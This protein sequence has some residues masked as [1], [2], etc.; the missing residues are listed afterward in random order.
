MT[1]E[2]RIWK[3]VASANFSPGDVIGV[4]V[5]GRTGPVV[6]TEILFVKISCRGRNIL[7][8]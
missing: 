6:L 3:E 2:G 1:L 7:V 5:G 8:W 4:W